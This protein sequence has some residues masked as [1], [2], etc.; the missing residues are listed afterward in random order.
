[1]S[2]TVL[3]PAFTSCAGVTVT[4]R[5]TEDFA[6]TEMAATCVESLVVL[7]VTLQPEGY[8]AERL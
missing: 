5:P 4:V 8:C 7:K 2:E 1:M 3:S 6:S